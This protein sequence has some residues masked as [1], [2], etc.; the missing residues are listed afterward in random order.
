M[1]PF[2][3][4][5]EEEL[6]L[7]TDRIACSLVEKPLDLPEAEHREEIASLV[8]RVGTASYYEILGLD[9]MA[10]ILAIHEAYE[11]LA[12]IVHPEHAERVGLAGRE[13]V[14]E[15][16]FEQVTEAYLT[17]SHSGNR[18]QYDRERPD[19]DGDRPPPVSRDQEAQR[20][21]EEARILAADE[22]FH[23]AVELLREAVRTTPKPDYLALLGLLQTKNPFWLRS[24]EEHLRR[25]IALG[26]KDPALPA[27]LE[28]VQRRIESGDTSHVSRDGEIL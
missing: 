12:R 8:R 6:R 2:R 17:L 10:P 21:Y 3:S 28:E 27:A 26:A 25:A 4:L 5:S 23:A 9:S 24:A 11:R 15:M 1:L 16:L 19:R 14:L 7:F 20:L 13:G 18:K 22:K